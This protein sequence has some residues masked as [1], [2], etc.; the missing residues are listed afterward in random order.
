MISNLSS[1]IP[2]AP[3][4][5]CCRNYGRWRVRSL[6]QSVLFKG[7]LLKSEL[8]LEEAGIADGDTVN[9]VPSK[10]PKAAASAVSWL[11]LTPDMTPDDGRTLACVFFLTPVV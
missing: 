9:I 2:L 5:V 7:N 3:P 6:D 1:S 11:A 4:R 8:D 10:K